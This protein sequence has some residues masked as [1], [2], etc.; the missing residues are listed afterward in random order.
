MNPTA[1]ED[2]LK[3]AARA[4]QVVAYAPYSKFHVGAAVRA[5]G[6]IFVGCNVENA[7]YGLCI[8]AERNA[9]SAAVIA[10]QRELQACVVITDASPPSAPC[11]MCR[12]TLREFSPDPTK[13]RVTAI[14]RQGE[15]RSWTVAQLLPD[16]FTG[17]ELP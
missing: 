13:V 3:D 1:D 8:C 2:E 5:G 6:K 11:G 10:G 7:S 14:N 9:I 4:A 15:Q 12:Q 16:G 17:A